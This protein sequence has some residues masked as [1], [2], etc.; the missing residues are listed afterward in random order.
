MNY[1]GYIRKEQN[2]GQ[3]IHPC[4][5]YYFKGIYTSMERNLMG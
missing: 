2:M 5:F 3:G 1:R 4:W